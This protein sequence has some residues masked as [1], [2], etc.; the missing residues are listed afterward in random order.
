[1]VIFT[2]SKG[3]G[4]NQL[5]RFTFALAIVLIHARPDLCKKHTRVPSADSCG[6]CFRQLALARR[7]M[8]VVKICRY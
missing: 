6:M 7:I 5:I 1:V 4:M 2:R 8:Q 3:L